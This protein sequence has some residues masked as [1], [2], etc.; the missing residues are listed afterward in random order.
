MYHLSLFTK[1]KIKQ[2]QLVEAW[3]KQSRETSFLSK[4]IICYSPVA[5]F[6]GHFWFSPNSFLMTLECQRFIFFYFCWAT[7]RLL[8]WIFILGHFWMTGAI[9]SQM[10]HELHR[11]CK[12]DLQTVVSARPKVFLGPRSKAAI[13]R[14]VN[15][16]SLPSTHV[17]L[18][19]VKYVQMLYD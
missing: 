12:M 5:R 9:K 13:P 15:C 14:V 6:F 17:G 16:G 19:F 10:K 2:E 1:F 8:S 3:I 11:D 18:S 7:Q 4:E